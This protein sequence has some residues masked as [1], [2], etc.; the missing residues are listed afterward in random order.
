MTQAAI[1]VKARS[2]GRIVRIVDGVTIDD[3][4]VDKV[5]DELART[6]GDR[7]VYDLSQVEAARRAAGADLPLALAC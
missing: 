7:Y 3:R 6:F 1:I 4:T 5:L 2:D